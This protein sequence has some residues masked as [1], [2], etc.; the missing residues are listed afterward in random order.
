MKKVIKKE[1]TKC[2]CT[3][4][5]SC[6]NMHTLFLVLILGVSIGVFY[7]Y[8]IV[9]TVNGKTISR[10]AYIKKLEKSDAK[11]LLEQMITETLIQS[12]ADKKGIKIDKN[13]IDEEIKKIDD[14]I[15]EQRQTLDLA[16]ESRGMT[17]ADLE[18]QINI[19]KIVEK[20]ATSSAE[21]T[22]AQIDEFLKTNKDMLPAKATKAELQELAKEQLIKQASDSAISAWLES[23]RKDAK[24]IYR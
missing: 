11:Q 14:Q 7:K 5:K 4:T 15:K 20:L 9:A 8:G 12:E 17:R 2:C 16:L 6:K 21:I 24:I 13:A 10:L 19:Q 18:G 1:E 23:I 22:Q 3:N